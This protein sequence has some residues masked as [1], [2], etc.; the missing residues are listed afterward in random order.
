MATSRFSIGMASSRSSALP[1]GTPSTTSISTTSASSY[2][3][4]Q[5]AA[6]APTLPAP[7]IVT[8]F[9]ILSSLQLVGSLNHLDDYRSLAIGVLWQA[10][11]VLDHARCKLAGL[12]LGRALHPALEVVG[13]EL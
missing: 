8:F 4:I 13:H 6:V 10:S 2:A 3:A 7:T 9:R 5:C 11:H 12:G 1:C